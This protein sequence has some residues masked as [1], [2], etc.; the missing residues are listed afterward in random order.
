[1][2][3]CELMK[4]IDHYSP[5]GCGNGLCSGIIVTGRNT[6][7]IQ[8]RVLPKYGRAQMT[9]PGHADAVVIPR[10][11]AAGRLFTAETGCRA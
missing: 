10:E 5:R 4:V 3:K 6:V 7:P 1:M 9:V 8:G 11:R 2:R